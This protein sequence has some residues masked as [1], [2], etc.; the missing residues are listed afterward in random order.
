MRLLTRVFAAVLVVLSLFLVSNQDENKSYDQVL[1]FPSERYPET[2]QH[3]QESIKKGHSDV[4]TIDREGA[5]NRRKKSLKDIPTK[6]GYD[7]DE[8]PMAMCEEGGEGADVK[9]I[10]PSDN[11]GAGSWVGHQVSEYPD[12]TRVLFI[13]D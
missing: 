2:A 10:S 6:K 7:R 13:V 9:Y 8:Y 1:N 5:D 11:R 3:I 4:C 12:G